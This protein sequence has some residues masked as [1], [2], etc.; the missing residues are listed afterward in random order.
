MDREGARGAQGPTGPSEDDGTDAPGPGGRAPGVGGEA[1]PD[2]E[3][4]AA[5]AEEQ[6][7]VDLAAATPAAGFSAPR[8]DEPGR[9]FPFGL[10]ALVLVLV[11]GW[12]GGTVA[13]QLRRDLGALEARLAATQ[14][15]AA[16]LE[17]LQAQAALLRVRADLEV[18]RQSMPEGL[19]AEVERADA[20]LGEVAG[21]HSGRP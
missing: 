6:R 8:R 15:R 16:R 1:L 10:A 20:I 14:D 5:V 19:A 18:L 13:W 12:V 3:D 11:L 2:P 4:A 21:H 7:T 17:G 9:P